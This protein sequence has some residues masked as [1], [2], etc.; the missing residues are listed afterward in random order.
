MCVGGISQ[1][2]HRRGVCGQP[3]PPQAT[4]GEIPDVFKKAPV[5]DAPYMLP[6][7]V[8]VVARHPLIGI[9]YSRNHG[10]VRFQ[11]D[12]GNPHAMMAQLLRIWKGVGESACDCSG[13]C[14]WHGHVNHS[15]RV[16]NNQVLV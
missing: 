9:A 13:C 4:R 15:Q 10:K 11:T 7:A 5:S 14:P 3:P 8:K 1:P 2:L 16:I 12:G 6:T